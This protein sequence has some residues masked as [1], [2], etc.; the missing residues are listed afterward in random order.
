MIQQIFFYYLAFASIGSALLTVGLR[1]PVYCGLALLS[2]LFHIAGFFILLHAEFLAAVQVIVY[3]GAILVLYLFVLMLLNLKAEER[4]F[5]KRFAFFLFFGFIVAGQGLLWLL[6]SPFAGNPGNISPA[7]MDE[8]GHTYALGIILFDQYFLPFE[9]IAVFL[10][11]AIIGA[12][13]LAKDRPTLA[14]KEVP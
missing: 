14:D 8:F 11:G 12:V 7:K 9:I 3:A 13:V 2:L 4:I 6:R 10:L 1:S 5:H